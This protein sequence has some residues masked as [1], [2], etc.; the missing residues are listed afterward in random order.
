[1]GKEEEL[2]RSRSP[3][4]PFSKNGRVPSILKDITQTFQSVSFGFNKFNL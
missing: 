4:L 3:N 2:K 1:M